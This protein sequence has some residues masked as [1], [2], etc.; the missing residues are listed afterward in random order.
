M[1]EAD[2][3]MIPTNSGLS[4]AIA[5]KFEPVYIRAGIGPFVRP[6]NL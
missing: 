4:Y 1:R 2:E 5:L 3:N 6:I